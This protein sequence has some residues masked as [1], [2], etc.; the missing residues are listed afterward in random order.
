G[1]HEVR[2]PDGS[3]SRILCISSATRQDG[4]SRRIGLDIAEKSVCEFG[5]NLDNLSSDET[6]RFTVAG[7][8]R[9]GIWRFDE[10]E[11]SPA[12]LVYPIFQVVNA[13]FF[14]RFEISHVCFCDV[15]RANFP[16]LMDVHV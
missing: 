8:C 2:E 14:L 1:I 4:R 10:T 7:V 15:L 6:V 11:D 5:L 12:L 9:F 13:V 16:K 3:N